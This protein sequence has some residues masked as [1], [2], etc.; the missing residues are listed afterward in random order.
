MTIETPTPEEE[1]KEAEV[2]PF[3]TVTGGKDGETPEDWLT[4]IL[5]GRHFLARPR[6]NKKIKMAP[7]PDG[8]NTDFM[9]MMYKVLWRGQKARQLLVY[10][11]QYDGRPDDTIV[12]CVDPMAFCREYALFEEMEP[13]SG[14][15]E[16]NSVG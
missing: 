8:I 1:E 5:E 13:E 4:P 10:V 15:N 16:T 6:K 14:D 3:S 9:L 7:I 11:N 12:I 2:L